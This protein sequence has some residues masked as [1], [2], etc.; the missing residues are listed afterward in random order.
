MHYNYEKIKYD[1]DLLRIQL[2]KSQGEKDIE[3]L[4]NIIF[5]TR[6]LSF[7][8]ILSLGFPCYYIFPWLFLSLSVFSNW[9]IIS[10]NVSHGCYNWTKIKKYRRGYFSFGNIRRMIDWLDWIL[11]EAWNIEHNKYHHYYLGEIKDPDLVEENISFLRESKIH[12]FYK[13]SMI[14]LMAISW[15]WV[16]YA[17]NTYKEY[18]LENLKRINQIEYNKIPDKVR[19]A[20]FTLL[21]FIRKYRDWMSGI[22]SIVLFPYFF[23]NFVFLPIVWY[24]LGLVFNNNNLFINCLVNVILAEI[25][26]NLHSFIVIVT[27]H[28][29]EDIYRFE[30][31]VKSRSGEFYVRQIIGSV[32]FDAGNDFVDFLHGWLNYQIEHHLFPDISLLAQRRA[33]PLVKSIC[34]KHKIPY[35]QENVF[36]RLMKLIKIMTGEKSMKV[37]KK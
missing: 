33:M 9:T 5:F 35:I 30:G 12:L 23:Y 21:T 13:Y 22:F 25:F 34:K 26:T 20:T 10:H 32:N 28:S 15:K 36:I 11:P 16:Y 19:N 18:C 31:S 3:H 7:I 2:A 6:I 29:G 37:W 4:E 17:P 24:V 27:N 14:F 8:G 1:F